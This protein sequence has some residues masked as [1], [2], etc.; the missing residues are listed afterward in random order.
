MSTIVGIDIG[1]TFTDLVSLSDG[2]LKTVKVAST[3]LDFSVGFSEALGLAVG[4]GSTSDIV[5][6]TTV[7][8][9]ALIQRKGARVG[10]ITTEGFRDILALRRRDR[11]T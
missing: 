4:E 11:R 7:A 9:N 2:K 6:A 5:H 3:P 10:M 1:G 8:T